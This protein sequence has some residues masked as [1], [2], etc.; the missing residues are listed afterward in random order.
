MKII[1]WNC[2]MAF[3]KKYQYLLDFEPNIIVI[4]EAE[5]FEWLQS[6]KIKEVSDS[7][8]IGDN[9]NK[10][11][12]VIAFNNITFNKHSS[13]DQSFKY[14][15]PLEVF[16]DE[17][18]IFNLIA[19]WAHKG[20]K[21]YTDY[22]H[23]AIKKY[24]SILNSESM[25]IGD[26]NSNKIWDSKPGLGNHSKTVELLE[27]KSIHSVY[28]SLYKE[29]FGEETNPTFFMY[30]HSNKPYHIDYCFA[31]TSLLTLRLV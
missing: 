5:N 22:T 10:G 30:H 31:S 21:S 19:V 11:L 24:D 2:K 18:F 14:F 25:L 8:W 26:F 3:R 27:K 7:I 28:H 12:G 17:S 15:L 23:A 20:K 1:S 16:I 6:Q 29:E 9:P 13:Y 4:Q